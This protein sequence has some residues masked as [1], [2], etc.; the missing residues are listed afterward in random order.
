MKAS[1]E[2]KRV[3]VRYVSHEIRTPLNTTQLGLDLLGNEV[4]EGVTDPA[5]LT[6]LISDATSSCA[7]AIT[8]L[9]DLLM[10]EKIDGGLL[11]LERS[12]M[13]VWSFVESV[14]K[15]FLIQVSVLC[16]VLTCVYNKL[17][18]LN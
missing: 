2:I 16:S 7:I 13:P 11:T 17:C 9:N 6:D 8:I 15:V 4:K 12:E 18:M 1:L 5:V 14:M 3:F 10:Y